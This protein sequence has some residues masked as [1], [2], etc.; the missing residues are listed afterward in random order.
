MD[1]VA[2]RQSIKRMRM[3]TSYVAFVT[4]SP[5]SVGSIPQAERSDNP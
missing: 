3:S 1:M 4:I 2:I 5:P